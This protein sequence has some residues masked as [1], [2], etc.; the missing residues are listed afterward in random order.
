MTALAG[1]SLSDDEH[2]LIERFTQEL[3]LRL[4]GHVHAVWL[5][6]SRARGE[7][8]SIDSDVDLL[9]LVDDASW[10]GRMLVRGMLDQV[11]RELGLDALTW[12][13]SIHVHTPA[14][15]AQRREIRSF[16]IAEVDRDK[17]V[18][19]GLT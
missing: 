3:R 8:P 2:A 16:F 13:F 12:S 18:L 5:F 15:L 11:A 19:G 7:R 9:V 6:G 14:W 17:V 1:T 4:E 10:D